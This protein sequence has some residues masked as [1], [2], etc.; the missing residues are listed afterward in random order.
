MEWGMNLYSIYSVACFE[1]LSRGLK[2]LKE[3]WIGGHYR[4]FFLYEI[5]TAKEARDSFKAAEEIS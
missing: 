3:L 4:N 1:W 2:A 5:E